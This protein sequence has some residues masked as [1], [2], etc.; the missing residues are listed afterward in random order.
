M[1]RRLILLV[2]SVNF[3][4]GLTLNTIACDWDLDPSVLLITSYNYAEKQISFDQLVYQQLKDHYGQRAVSATFNYQDD[5]SYA[6]ILRNLIESYHLQKVF[7]LDPSFIN[8]LP[9]TTQT[10]TKS[11][12]LIR[13]FQQFTNVQFYFFNNQIANNIKISSNIFE[14]RLN[15]ANHDDLAPITYGKQIATN[16][17]Q[18]LTMSQGQQAGYVDSKKFKFDVDQDGHWVIKVGIINNIGNEYQQQIINQFREGLA[19]SANIPKDAR[20]LIYDINVKNPI[21]SYNEKNISLVS[22]A[23]IKLYS[24]NKVNF[25][26]NT[27]SWYNNAIDYAA[28][29][30]NNLLGYSKTINF[31][32]SS[33]TDNK[34]YF[35][36]NRDFLLFSYNVDLG[37]LDYTTENKLPDGLKVLLDAPERDNAFGINGALNFINGF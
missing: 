28:S 7:I 1:F 10:P 31:I 4:S 11:S 27:N 21:L 18:Q 26:L 24:I 32:G 15:T 6:I 22:Q 30:V 14:F 13:L 16:L 5:N 19:L 2:M 33:I 35:V 20:Y 12:N 37:F 34:T 23:A 9:H 36:N 29:Y 8:Y 3:M 17:Y 25:I